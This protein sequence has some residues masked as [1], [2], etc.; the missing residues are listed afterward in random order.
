MLQLLLPENIYSCYVN[1]QLITDAWI[2]GTEVNEMRPYKFLLF[3]SAAT[4]ILSSC[5]ATTYDH[6]IDVG[7]YNVSFFGETDA[8]IE[9]LHNSTNQEG[10]TFDYYRIIVHSTQWEPEIKINLI[11]IA[12]SR[13]KLSDFDIDPESVLATVCNDSSVYCDG[14]YEGLI[15]QKQKAEFANIRS[16][17]S[18]EIAYAACYQVDPQTICFFTVLDDLPWF[19]LMQDPGINIEKIHD[20]PSRGTSILKATLLGENNPNQF[21]PTSIPASSGY[22]YN[23]DAGPYRISF[24]LNASILMQPMVLPGYPYMS[25]VPVESWQFSISSSSVEL[26]KRSDG[27][28]FSQIDFARLA[29]ATI[30]QEISN[31][32]QIQTKWINGFQWASSSGTSG[33][34]GN[35]LV[36]GIKYVGLFLPDDYT[37]CRITTINDQDEFKTLA[38]S[39]VVGGRSVL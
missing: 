34:I 35:T 14:F 31:H 26:L 22:D 9:V 1:P 30:T 10:V 8:N 6:S 13:K 29:E 25:G 39:I 16:P 3:F 17:D 24:T 18:D 37:I 33:S 38:N 21:S 19:Y 5:V 28:T 23:V 11:T 2:L 12:D 36:N 7:S 15:G 32:G 4:L 27:A 20:Q